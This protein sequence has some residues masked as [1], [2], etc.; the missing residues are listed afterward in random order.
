MATTQHASSAGPE[1]EP[2]R[3]HELMTAQ[4][5]ATLLSVPATWVYA[6]TRAGRIP[7][8]RLGRY[9][10]YRP[11]AIADWLEASER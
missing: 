9:Y 3:A 2:R 10:R 6:Q 5:V 7:A 1:T 4:Q 11:A 8:I